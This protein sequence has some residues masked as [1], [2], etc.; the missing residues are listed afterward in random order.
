MASLGLISNLVSVTTKIEGREVGKRNNYFGVL[1]EKV[2]CFR[3][4]L[5]CLCNTP[6]PLD[7]LMLV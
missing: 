7:Q 6:R 3:V 5:K 4:Y 2:Q 1:K